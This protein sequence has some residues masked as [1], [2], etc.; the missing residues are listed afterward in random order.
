M[1]LKQLRVA[2]MSSTWADGPLSPLAR[3]DKAAY[4]LLDRPVSNMMK[5]MPFQT[6]GN[7]S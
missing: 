3:I 4:H 7:F 5:Y 2:A 1:R 6:E